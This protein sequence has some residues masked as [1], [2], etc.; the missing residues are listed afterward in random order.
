MQFVIRDKFKPLV[1]SIHWRGRC[2]GI[3]FFQRRTNDVPGVN[4]FIVGVHN[5]HGELQADVL[6]DFAWMVKRRPYGTKVLAVGDWNVD[7]L[8]TLAND[9]FA[10]CP[11]REWHH[12][13]ERA[14]LDF[15]ADQLRLE[16]VL[17]QVVA[18]IPGGP[19]AP[20]CSL[21]PLAF[22]LASRQLFRLRVC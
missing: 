15:C 11:G 18:S 16:I 1:W 19:F 17:P 12:W 4:L 5:S 2:G 14:R 21:A 6:A 9:P 3:H 20:H 13:Q 8:P 22:R 10:D 7:Q